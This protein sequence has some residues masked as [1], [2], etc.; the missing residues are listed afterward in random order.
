VPDRGRRVPSLA[1]CSMQC[2][3][4]SA[5][6]FQGTLALCLR[7][8]PMIAARPHGISR[9]PRSLVSR[10]RRRYSRADET[11]ACNQ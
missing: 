3:R 5:L 4:N 1:C 2:A 6:A 10:C 11:S 9:P 8:H 7:G